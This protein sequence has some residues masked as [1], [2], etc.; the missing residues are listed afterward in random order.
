MGFSSVFSTTSFSSFNF[1]R[2]GFL[3]VFSFAFGFYCRF[4]WGLF[5]LYS[6]YSQELWAQLL[7][8]WELRAQ[9]H[10]PTRHQ[11]RPT[12]WQVRISTSMV[13]LNEKMTLEF[14]HF[15][16]D[17]WQWFHARIRLRNF[18]K[19]L[20]ANILGLVFTFQLGSE[21]SQAGPPRAQSVHPFHPGDLTSPMEN[22]MQI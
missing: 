20:A 15:S 4:L 2:S 13:L 1:F 10:H 7:L 16:F 17:T 14:R 5:F 9:L 12:T 3:P 22:E 8:Q 21:D 19:T 11:H 18:R 6:L